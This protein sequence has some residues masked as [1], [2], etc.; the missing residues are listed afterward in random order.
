MATLKLPHTHRPRRKALQSQNALS[1]SPIAAFALRSVFRLKRLL[2]QM[3]APSRMPSTTKAARWPWSWPFRQLG[4]AFDRYFGEFYAFARICL[5]VLVLGLKGWDRGGTGSE[6]EDPPP[7]VF[8][9]SLLRIEAASW[10]GIV[11]VSGSESAGSSGSKLRGPSGDKSGVRPGCRPCGLFLFLAS[12][13]LLVH[14]LAPWK[15]GPARGR[16][17]SPHI[18]RGCWTMRIVFAA[19]AVGRC[20]AGGSCFEGSKP[21]IP[22]EPCGRNASPAAPVSWHGRVGQYCSCITAEMP[23]LHIDFSKTSVAGGACFRE[24]TVVPRIEA[25]DRSTRAAPTGCVRGQLCCRFVGLGSSSGLVV[26]E[27]FVGHL[28]VLLAC[29]WLSGCFCGVVLQCLTS[30]AEWLLTLV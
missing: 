10:S 3:I 8:F 20:V 5:G 12:S 21:A 6:S 22:R 15:P 26:L 7:T 30:S 2:S 14:V 9:Q 28:G 4:D 11:I 25:M 27:R 29:S 19:D 13:V 18:A 1:M 16:P 23:S 24:R 17:G